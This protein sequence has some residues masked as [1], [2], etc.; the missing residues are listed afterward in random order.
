[1][2]NSMSSRSISEHLCTLA[3]LLEAEALRC[4][5][6]GTANAKELSRRSIEVRSMAEQ[7][8]NADL[9]LPVLGNAGKAAEPAR[10]ARDAANC[11]RAVGIGERVAALV[12]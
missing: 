11:L 5:A 2:M 12:S 10:P 9:M 7:L 4:T 3:T 6:L 8:W 1:M